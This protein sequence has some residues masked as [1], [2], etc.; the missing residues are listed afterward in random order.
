MS[1]ELYC[2]NRQCMH[3]KSQH[4]RARRVIPGDPLVFIV[5]LSNGCGCANRYSVLDPDGTYQ[6]ESIKEPWFMTLEQ[7]VYRE[8]TTE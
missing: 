5:C 7:M 1:D 8:I 2:S 4:A 6:M 3:S